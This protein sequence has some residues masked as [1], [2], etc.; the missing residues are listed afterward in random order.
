MPVPAFHHLLTLRCWRK[1]RPEQRGHRRPPTS[2][3]G[4]RRL[5][6]GHGGGHGPQATAVQLLPGTSPHRRVP[7]SAPPGI[8][9]G[10]LT[11]RTLSRPPGSPAS[12]ANGD[13]TGG[14]CGPQRLSGKARGPP[15]PGPG[16]CPHAPTAAF[17]VPAGREARRRSPRPLFQGHQPSEVP[18]GGH[19]APQARGA[20]SAPALGRHRRGLGGRL[21]P[22]DVGAPG[23]NATP[24][25]ALPRGRFHRARPHAHTRTRSDHAPPAR[26]SS[27]PP[28]FF[29]AARAASVRGVRVSRA[30]RRRTYHSRSAGLPPTPPAPPL[31]R[32]GCFSSQRA[33]HSRAQPRTAPPSRAR[34]RTAP[35]SRARPRTA[36]PSRAQPRTAPP[37]RARPRTAPPSRAQPRTAAHG[38]AQPRPAAHS[39]AHSRARPRPAAPSGARPRTAPHSRAQPRTAAHGPAQPRLAAHGPAQPR[40]AAHS[41]ARPR[42]APHSRAQP[43]TAPPSRAQ[44]RA[45]PRTAPPSRAQ[46]R[47]AP[48][49]PAQPRTAPHSR[50]QPRAQPR[51]AAHSRAQP[52]PAAHGPAQ[53]RTAAHSPAQPRT[54]A[55]SP[56]QPRTAPRTAAHSRAQPRPAAHGPAQPRTAAHSPAQLARSPRNHERARARLSLQGALRAVLTEGRRG[57]QE[58]GPHRP[59]RSRRSRS[60]ARVGRRSRRAAPLPAGLRSPQG[61]TPHRAPLPAGRR[62]S[63]PTAGGARSPASGRVQPS[64]LGRALRSADGDRAGPR[65][66]RRCGGLRPDRAAQERA[67]RHRTG[68]SSGPHPA[69]RCTPA[70]RD[71][72]FQAPGSEG[73]KPGQTRRA[74]GYAPASVLVSSFSALRDPLWVCLPARPPPLPQRAPPGPP[75][76]TVLLTA[77]RAPGRQ[78]GLSTGRCTCHGHHRRLPQG[79]RPPSDG[80][81]PPLP[82]LPQP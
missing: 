68:P 44:P 26:D 75:L 60:P 55:H 1:A 9:H 10:S 59:R 3:D 5:C 72:R 12:D 17:R 32:R 64:L 80:D 24:G 77:A 54:A 6:P 22:G 18:T 7:S 71:L 35:P 53:P 81:I 48:H 37:S 45:Q 79:P 42:T 4:Q 58:A 8:P 43:R 39:P 29:G 62:T 25:P 49:S 67:R 15:V 28:R 82:C 33:P 40:T 57:S 2:G 78:V 27:P 36:Q 74:K 30:G 16:P 11:R 73:T 63:R 34:P 66:G 70:E 23:G 13:P 61:S 47:T 56:A 50:A 51:T 65:A 52:R 41:R 69:T 46:R 21:G 76:Q 14:H 38:P 31:R 19:R 20:R